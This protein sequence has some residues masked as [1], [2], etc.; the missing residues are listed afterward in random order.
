MT[1]LG[2]STK[3]RR[4]QTSA[5]RLFVSSK[6]LIRIPLLGLGCK[7]CARSYDTNRPA[8]PGAVRNAAYPD[9]VL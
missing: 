3:G 8:P 5:K 7:I 9:G 1:N 4:T 2:G 6:S